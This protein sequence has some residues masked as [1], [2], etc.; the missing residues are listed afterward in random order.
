[1]SHVYCPQ[2]GFLN[3]EAANFC[4]KCAALLVHEAAGSETTISLTAG[5]VEEAD[6]DLVELGVK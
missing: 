1:M 5:E 4:A 3:P 2:C 6:L